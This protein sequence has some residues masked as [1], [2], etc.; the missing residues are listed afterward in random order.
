M[1]ELVIQS[2]TKRRMKSPIRR[3]G[4]KHYM[5]RHLLELMP[6]HKAYVEPFGGAG[7][8]LFAKEP[9]HCEV[10][11]DIDDNLVNLFRVIRDDELGAELERRLRWT[12]YSRREFRLAHEMLHSGDPVDRAWAFFITIRQS[13]GAQG[14]KSWGYGRGDSYNPTAYY[15]TVDMLSAVR[16]R[17]RCVHIEHDDFRKIIKRYDTPET[18]FY[19]DPPYYGVENYYSAGMSEQDHI[20]LLELLN[21]IRGMA[22]VSGY[23]SD[24]YHEML[25]RR[26][27]S[28][29]EFRKPLQLVARSAGSRYVGE[30]ALQDYY[31]TE[32]VW[33]NPAA[34]RARQALKLMSNEVYA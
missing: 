26:G 22:M 34:E 16:E 15:A 24:L 30:G 28:R 13:F 23:D 3:V 19:C 4:G 32:V 31:R 29:Y 18:L 21:N 11:N 5:V 17:L 14:Y 8:L 1:S 33:L 9:A 27:W 6:P 12:L 10:Y 7:W 20:D 25:D 2:T